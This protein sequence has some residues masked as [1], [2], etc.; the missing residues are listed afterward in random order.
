VLGHGVAFGYDNGIWGNQ[1]EQGVRVRLPIARHWAVLARGIVLHAVGTA[2]EPY[3]MGAGG[4]LEIIGFSDVLHGFA[5]MYGGGGVQVLGTV[6]G[7]STPLGVA[8]GGEFGAEM[9][10]TPKLAFY[11]EIGG[12]GGAKDGFGAGGTAIAGLHAYPF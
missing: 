11:F 10:V 6:T 4:R 8:G 1:F 12:T 5:R 2:M 3:R 7:A 9:F